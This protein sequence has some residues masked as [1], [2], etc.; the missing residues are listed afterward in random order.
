M[1]PWVSARAGTTGTR[2]SPGHSSMHFAAAITLSAFLIFL[3]QPLVAKQILP[4][5]GGSAAVWTTCMVFFQTALLAGYGYA[6]WAPR[7]LGIRRHARIHAVLALVSLIALPITVSTFW[8][9]EGSTMPILGILGLLTATIGLPYFVL[10]ATSPLVQMWFAREHPQ[11]DPYRLFAL[12]NTASLLA[13]LCYPFV[14]EPRMPLHDQAWLWSS[15][16][17]LF[18]V[19]I[20]AL[21]VRVA[22]HPDL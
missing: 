21:I 19:L 3:V 17:A 12:S 18:V 2:K 22:R 1:P 8:K 7:R 5:F 11:Q 10:S 15:L 14:I 20:V 13:L 9:P 4:W 16:Y 6:D